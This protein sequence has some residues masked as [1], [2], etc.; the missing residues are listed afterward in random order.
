[1]AEAGVLPL[2][3][4]LRIAQIAHRFFLNRKRLNCS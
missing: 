3:G 4:D 2:D 1:M